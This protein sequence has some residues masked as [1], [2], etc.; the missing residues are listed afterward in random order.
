M[1]IPRLHPFE[2]SPPRGQ[3]DRR[4]PPREELGD[5]VQR[6]EDR[7]APTALLERGSNQET[8]RR[9]GPTLETKEGR[10]Y[11]GPRSI[12]EFEHFACKPHQRRRGVPNF[13][14]H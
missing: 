10:I 8:D 11:P 9:L 12:R 2:S 5:R 14:A 1:S 13:R 4:I 6:S 7:L 3:T